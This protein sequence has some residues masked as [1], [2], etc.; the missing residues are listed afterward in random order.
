MA[1]LLLLT[2]LSLLSRSSLAAPAPATNTTRGRSCIDLTLS[3]PINATNSIYDIPRVDSN[4]DAVYYVWDL[5]TWSSPN[6]TER[7]TG[8][9][10]VEQTF[11]ISAQLCV[12]IRPNAGKKDIL[13]IAT[14]GFGFDKRYWDA[15]LHP[16]TYSYVDAALAAG[17]SILTYDRLGVGSSDKPDA[18]DVVQVPVQVEILKKIATLARSGAL[19]QHA[20]SLPFT[21]PSFNKTVLVGHS[22]GSGLTISVLAKYPHLADGAVSTGL[23]PNTQ[24]GA[25]GQRAFGLEYAATSNP[26]R[27]GD[28]GSGYVVQGT[29]SALQQVFFK[30]G[31]FDP[32]VLQYADSIKETGTAGEFVSFGSALEKPALEYTG[33]ILFALAEYDF[34]TC[35]GDCKGTYN[36]TAIREGLFPAAVDVSVQVQPGSGHALTLHTNATGHYEAVFEYLSEWGL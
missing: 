20:S 13:Q 36:V 21:V 6:A 11:N 27:F 33:P 30:K 31:Y 8:T 23:I 29:I 19:V 22:Y 14:H 5:D 9:K 15:T 17:Y 34:G 25:A 16:E 4:I 28:R 12:P 7:I 18:Y 35:L 10:V 26:S 2:A 24:V 32:E 3:L 1:S